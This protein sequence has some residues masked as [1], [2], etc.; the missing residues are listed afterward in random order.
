MAVDSR[1]FDLVKHLWRGGKFA[2]YWTPDTDEGKLSWWFDASKPPAPVDSK[3]INLY[4][5]IHTCSVNKGMR[6][7]A[8]IDTI[9]AINCLFAEFDLAKGQQPEHL[10]EAINQL[11]VAP[12]VIIFS[13]GGYHCYWLLEQTY[14]IDSE[15]ARQRIIDIQYAWDDFTTGDNHVKDLARV[16]RIPGTYNRKPEYAP[17]FPLVEIIKF[18]MDLVYGLDELYTQVESIIDTNKAKKAAAIQTDVVDVDLDDHV[19][20]EKMLERDAKAAALWAG[21][22]A[23]YGDDHSDADLA[24]CNKLAFWF[25][26]DRDRMDRVFRNSALF[27]PKWLRDDYR[28]KTLDKAIANCGATY[29]PSSGNLGNPQDLIKPV[30]I[31]VNGSQPHTNGTT[32]QAP[33]MAASAQMSIDDLLV[34]YSP[35]DWGNTQAVYLLYGQDFIYCPTHGYLHYNGKYWETEGAE[36]HLTQAVVD[37]LI[38]RRTIAVARS[39]EAVVKVTKPDANKVQNCIYFFKA[40]VEKS[41]DLFD[42]NPGFLNCRNGA[43]NLQTGELLPHDAMQYFT[44][45]VPVDYDLNANYAPWLTF[46]QSTVVSSDVINYIKMAAGYTATGYTREECLFYVHGPTRSGKGTFAETLLTLLCKPIGVQTDFATFTAKR[47]GDTQNFDLA[48]LRPARFIVASESDKYD[49]LNEAKV[50]TITG[51]DWIRCAFKHRT[52]FEYRPQ[53]KVWLLS[54]HPIKGDVDDDAFWGRVK[55][56]NFPNSHLGQEDKTLKQRMKSDE[57]LRGVLRWIV[58]GAMEWFKNPQGLQAPPVVNDANKQR[59]LELDYVQQWIDACCRI[60]SAAW[61]QNNAVYYSYKSWCE[62]VGIKPKSMETLSQILAKKGCRI[63]VQR[64]IGNGQRQRGI[65]GISIV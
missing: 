40:L 25:G 50:K 54:N 2:Y 43:V 3:F 22:L 12:S 34:N 35:D 24:L 10:L 31:P 62:G 17:N 5:G 55:I 41:V 49:T 8:T 52:H 26:R 36:A 6:Q 44:Y 27:R 16:L 7:R 1:F 11:D 42:A 37:T 63:S 20:V 64:R 65:E 28:N 15:D 33:Q 9:D 18:D 29:T 38:R 58:E 56:I 13:G 48:P 47:E 19:I 14:F 45:C 61:T 4:F 21:D 53:F 57:N 46:L 32:S 59:R 30:A 39:A 51:G 60:D 23:E